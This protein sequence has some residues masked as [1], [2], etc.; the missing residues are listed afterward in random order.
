VASLTT[1]GRRTGRP[2][3]TPVTWFSDGEDIITVAMYVGMERDPDWCL[4]LEAHPEATIVIAGQPITVYA[5]RTTDE[6]RRRLWE[7]W[8]EI[9]PVSR[10]FE[11][12]AKRE[13]PVYRL[14][15]LADQMKNKTETDPKS[16]P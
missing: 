12:I 7:R 11:P 15:P 9:Q 3:S 8:L 14:T 13:I 16:G 4:N 2:R 1:S 6:E 10:L 5:R